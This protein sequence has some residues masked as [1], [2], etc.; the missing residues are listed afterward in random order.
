MKSLEKGLG[1]LITKIDTEPQRSKSTMNKDHKGSLS[2]LTQM[3][4]PVKR[5]LNDE[6]Q[7]E[8]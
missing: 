1:K 2:D 4:I 8:L 6:G 7:K 5:A 3:R